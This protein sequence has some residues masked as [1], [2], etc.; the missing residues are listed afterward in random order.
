[1]KYPAPSTIATIGL[2]FLVVFPPWLFGAVQAVYQQYLFGIAILTFALALPVTLWPGPTANRGGVPLACLPLLLVIGLASVQLIPLSS[3]RLQA[4]SPQA[5]RWWQVASETV[6]AG[7]AGELPSRT[8]SLHPA[9]SRHDLALLGLPVACFVLS[10][11]M[12]TKREHQLLICGLAAAN[13][14]AFA[15]F[16]IVQQLTYNGRLYWQVPLRYGGV[17]FAAFV[18]RNHAGGYLNLCLASALALLIWVLT[19]SRETNDFDQVTQAQAWGSAWERWR[20]AIFTN[21]TA[22]ALVTVALAATI[23]AGVVCSLSRGAI[24]ALVVACAL[25]AMMAIRGRQSSAVATL[26]LLAVAGGVALALWLGRGV[27]LQERLVATVTDVGAAT[28]SRIDHWQDVLAACRD[29]WATGSGLG[30]YRYA[31]RPYESQLYA[32]WFYHAENQYLEAM[33]EGGI[34]GLCL[35][36]SAICCVMVAAYR[37]V[38]AK[39]V[40]RLSFA[41]GI[42]GLFAVCSQTTHGFFDFGLYLPAN[43]ALFAILAGMACAQIPIGDSADNLWVTMVH[44]LS[45][46]WHALVLCLAFA[47]LVWGGWVIHQTAGVETTLDQHWQLGKDNIPAAADLQEAIDELRPRLSAGDAEAHAR[48]A[49]W[50]VLAY[51]LAARDDLLA[52][53]PAANAESAWNLTA[54]LL[55]HRRAH[56]LYETDQPRWERL[57]NQ[58][59]VKQ[60]LTVA[61]NELLMADRQCPLISSVY[62]SLAELS[63]AGQPRLFEKEHR[64]LETA[65][66]LAPNDPEV[67]FRCGL[68]ELQAGRE[69]VGFDR[70]RKCLALTSAY[71][72]QMVV[73]GNEITEASKWY[74]RILPEIPERIIEL[75]AFVPSPAERLDLA[76][77]AEESLSSAM[78]D[79]ARETYLLG[80]IHE[81]RGDMLAAIE[82]YQSAVELSPHKLKWRYEL[83]RASVAK[84]SGRGSPR[85]RDRVF[86]ASTWDA[87][88]SRAGQSHSRG[89]AALMGCAKLLTTAGRSRILGVVHSHPRDAQDRHVAFWQHR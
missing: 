75:A 46:C 56:E 16:G 8:I 10:S 37:L 36:V 34:V 71:A 80:R 57:R 29:Y 59:L 52:S 42:C 39:S 50:Q 9:S 58:P 7:D 86:A 48:M 17:P 79:A 25:V 2:A 4:V 40:D 13:G 67:L 73:L 70:W 12:L 24:L 3:Q 30:T 45:R 78:Y 51:R 23:A 63:L 47:W 33:V 64:L 62:M 26:S 5:E 88:P 77:R 6:A 84:R 15:L 28:N 87:A 14:A 74:A 19:R 27:F 81:L 83:S 11:L 44:P 65:V 55:L 21:L 60:H 38:S 68:L 69:A 35:M 1:M 76:A 82:C 72:E 22:S 49:L 20:F 89:T 85:A 66:Q 41:M 32:G 43:A 53:L 61:L 18:N 54:P 31:Y